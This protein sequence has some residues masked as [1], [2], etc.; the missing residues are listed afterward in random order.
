M[1]ADELEKLLKILALIQAGLA[2]ANEILANKASQGGMDT[3][4]IF[5]RASQHNSDALDIINAL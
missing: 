2:K 5:D 3:K 4:A 1:T